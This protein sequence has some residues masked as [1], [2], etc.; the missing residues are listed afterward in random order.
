MEYP[1]LMQ[2]NQCLQDLIQ[3]ALRL[4]RIERLLSS[5]AHKLLQVEFNVL[6]NQDKLL[7]L[8]D[9]IF[10]PASKEHSS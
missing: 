2:M 4:V 6:K 5:L 3:K 9:N 1:M 7:L 8:I 10:Q